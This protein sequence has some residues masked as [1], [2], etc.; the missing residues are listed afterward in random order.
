[1]HPYEIASVLKARGKG[2]DMAIRWGSPYRVMQNLEKYGFVRTVQSERRGGRPER[3]VYEIT[4]AGRYELADWTRELVGVPER[5]ELRFKAGLSVLGVLSPDEVVVLLRK[6]IKA[7]EQ[8]IAAARVDLAR[9][10]EETMRLFLVESEYELALWSAAAEWVRG[11][12]QELTDGSL[13]G[14]AEWRDFPR[15]D[16]GRRSRPALAKDP[17]RCCNTALGTTSNR[18]ACGPAARWRWRR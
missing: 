15:S 14:L 1:M 18:T 7:L 13:E 8:Q 11:L 17:A 16:G 2:R 9:Q 12:L 5:E 3:T 4:A 6:R 10:A